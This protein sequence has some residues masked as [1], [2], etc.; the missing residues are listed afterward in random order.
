MGQG[1]CKLSPLM[2]TK[3]IWKPLGIAV[4]VLE[5]LFWMVK[6]LGWPNAGPGGDLPVS[7]LQISPEFGFFLISTDLVPIRQGV[8]ISPCACG[9]PLGWMVIL[10][11]PQC[12]NLGLGKSQATQQT[13][14]LDWTSALSLGREHQSFWCVCVY[15]CLGGWTE[16]RQVDAPATCSY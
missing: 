15:I 6:D 10:T 1:Y 5:F 13:E 2:V 7:Q 14:L 11:Y 16:R 4:R 8:L 12:G 9:T 3:N